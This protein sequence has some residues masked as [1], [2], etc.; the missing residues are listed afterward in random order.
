MLLNR[1]LPPGHDVVY[2]VSDAPDPTRR[3]SHVRAMEAVRSTASGD[4]GATTAPARPCADLEL[5]EVKAHQDSNRKS[6]L[7]NFVVAGISCISGDNP[8]KSIF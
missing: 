3:V 7:F 1:N 8:N 4:T 5:R 2:T 6:N